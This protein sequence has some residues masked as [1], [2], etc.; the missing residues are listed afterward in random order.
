MPQANFSVVEIMDT[1]LCGSVCSIFLKP[2]DILH[3][4]REH[5]WERD[6][7]NFSTAAV[8]FLQLLPKMCFYFVFFS[9]DIFYICYTAK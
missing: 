4:Y 6:L 7:C 9:V 2:N 5:S 1:I 8:L 3:H